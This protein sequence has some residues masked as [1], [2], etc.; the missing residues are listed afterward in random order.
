MNTRR[1]SAR[2]AAQN[3]HSSEPQLNSVIIP[4]LT[5]PRLK[6]EL[7]KRKL[8][9]TGRKEALVERLIEYI[10]KNGVVCDDVASSSQ[11]KNKVKMSTE[12]EAIKE[13][14]IEIKNE[15][16]LEEFPNV[17]SEN[18]EE[19]IDEDVNK[20]KDTC[21][22]ELNLPP[23]V[24]ESDI[25]ENTN[26]PDTLMEVCQPQESERK[27]EDVVDTCKLEADDCKKS[28]ELEE[29]KIQEIESVE[30]K[31]ESQEIQEIESIE[32]K[33]E[34]QEIQE[35]ESIED[36]VE[37]YEIQEIESIED[38]NEEP[39]KIQEIESSED[40][41]VEPYKIQEIE[42]IEDRNVEPC[43]NQ[44]IESIEDKNEEPFKIQEIESIEDKVEPCINQEME[45]SEDKNVE[46]CKIQ[47]VEVIKNIKVDS[48][49]IQ[50]NGYNNLGV[51][52]LKRKRRFFEDDPSTN[53]SNI[54]PPETIVNLVEHYNSTVQGRKKSYSSFNN[55]M[56]SQDIESPCLL[57][58]DENIKE[59]IN[60]GN[61]LSNTGNLYERMSENLYSNRNDNYIYDNHNSTN[62]YIK[63]TIMHSDEQNSDIN[64][65]E[66]RLAE[67][68][69]DPAALLQKATAVLKNLNDKTDYQY[70]Q[71]PCESTFVEDVKPLP[72][73]HGEP[74][75]SDVEEDDYFAKAAGIKKKKDKNAVVIPEEEA[76]PMNDEIDL[77]YYNAD[78]HIKASVDDKWLIEPENSDGFALMWGG[79]R[80]NY[81]IKYDKTLSSYNKKFCFQVKIIDHLSLK[82]V[83]FEEREP[84]DIR[85]GWSLNNKSQALG[86]LAGTYCFNSKAMKAS[87]CIF[88]DYGESFSINDVITTIFDVSCG[89]ISYYKNHE[90]L[91]VAFYETCFKDGDAI[92]AHIAIK[93]CKVKVNFGHGSEED[94]PSRFIPKDVY[95]LNTMNCSEEMIRSRQPPA[96]K[97]DCTVIMTVGLP[98]SG[99]T[100]WVRQYLRDNPDGHWRVISSD[101]LLQQM[102]IDGIPRKQVHSG[103]WDMVMGLAAKAVVKAMGLACRRK[104]NYIIDGTNV[105]RDARKRKLAQFQD[106]QRKCVVLIPPEKE[107]IHRQMKQEKQDGIRP[108]PAEAMLELKATMSIPELAE[109]PVE[110]IIFV[111]PEQISHAL[112]IVENYNKEGEPWLIQKNKQ[113]RQKHNAQINNHS[114]NN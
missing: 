27:E 5:V 18:N 15:I 7:S 29:C 108:I 75:Q 66:N 88:S 91:G 110:D 55:Y 45:S 40:K 43:I 21:S 61:Q 42:S 14:N 60:E 39:F 79:I 107:L 48:C 87:G 65:S 37:P 8:K 63:P 36:K 105:S 67:L 44:D 99:K 94:F 109:E 74:V 53:E 102:R 68:M 86:D 46:S 30:D 52:S 28:E 25:T 90:F 64:G 24:E 34:P 47:E 1:S 32:D 112:K 104:H 12:E 83:P 31:V 19:K 97:E 57:E 101:A 85:V 111:E 72:E 26:T 3:G 51:K 81:G 13:N 78:L 16:P 50:E 38:K 114:V 100:T 20:E 96:R 58:I 41:N 73:F 10:N 35:I 6:E 76:P 80:S 9:C 33:V 71:F 95:F 77:D 106:F 49:R 69:K 54:P 11:S 113:K 62:E 23:K 4:F 22:D 92:F 70:E 82:H 56:S 84:Y 59:S 103:R 2:I 89:H 17:N 93:N 98:G